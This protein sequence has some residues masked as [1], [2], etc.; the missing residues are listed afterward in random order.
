[1]DANNNANVDN[2]GITIALRKPIAL[3]QVKAYKY[4]YLKSAT[5]K[6]YLLQRDSTVIYV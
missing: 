3:S 2:R 6:Q 1:M 4:C 5:Y